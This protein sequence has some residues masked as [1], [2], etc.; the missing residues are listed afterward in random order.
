MPS[1]TGYG[2]ATM[3]PDD[4]SSATA[5]SH[6]SLSTALGAEEI[7]VDVY[8]LTAG[9]TVDLLPGRER[10]VVPLLGTAPVVLDGRYTLAHGTIGRLAPDR[11]C[12]IGGRGDVSVLVVSVATDDADT[13]EPVILDLGT[14]DYVTP[15]TSD[16]ATA[17]LTRPLGCTGMKVNARL[18]E[19]GQA[20]PTHVEG[21]Q[22]ELFVPLTDGATMSVDDE[23]VSTPRGTIV[24]VG[25][26]VPR[27]ARNDGETDGQWLMFGAP[28]TGGP[29]DWDPGA[30]VVE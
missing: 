5:R 14:V 27:S 3:E 26:D 25:H 10:V 13:T 9:E 12:T 18:L 17:H 21:S 24:R 6:R 7:D 23:Q 30:R 4:V 15:S 2:V 22:E 28:P 8:R 16:V 20:V 19:S 11:P 29:A 1:T